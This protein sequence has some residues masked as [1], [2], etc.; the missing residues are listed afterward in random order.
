MSNALEV[1]KGK[2]KLEGKVVGISNEN[3]YREG[4]TASDKP[5]KALAFFVETSKTNRVKVEMFGMERDEV[6]F[7]SSKEKKSKRVAWASRNDS[8][9]EYKLLGVNA[10]LE[11]SGDKK[12]RK[13]L[14]EYDMIDYIMEHIAEGD[15][16]RIGGEADFQQFENQQGEIVNTVKYPIKSITK[17]KPID[18]DAE[19]FKEV[20]FFEQE[21]V[22]NDTMHDSEENKLLLSAYVI[23]YKKDGN[24]AV[25]ADFVV[26]TVE[27][28]K[29]AKNMLNRFGFG[30]TI[31]VY[32]FIKNETI[33]RE[34]EPDEVE[35]DEDALDWNDEDEDDIQSTFDTQYIT[36]YISELRITSVDSSSYEKAKYTEDDF[37][38]SEED[39]FNGDFDEDDD[40]FGD[41]E[42]SEVDDLPFD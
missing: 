35:V 32:G 19:D 31:K 7:Y 17:I 38:S 37:M 1:T 30:D 2:I 20:A 25:S 8:I 11:G 39:T 40:D 26:D 23:K 41:D 28:P 10:F 16:V 34:A 36:E 6:V 13:V 21:I 42:D 4:F 9:K 3:A 24:E 33:Q 29:L 14:V 27:K 15:F 18:F 12:E 22:I 5:Y